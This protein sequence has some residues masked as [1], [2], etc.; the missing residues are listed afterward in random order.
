MA[1]AVNFAT[2]D[3]LKWGRQ[4]ELMCVLLLLLLLLLAATSQHTMFFNHIFAAIQF[5]ATISKHR[6]CVTIHK[7]LCNNTQ[8]DT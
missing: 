5:C 4:S 6:N 8:T 1:E 7:Q 2:I 3:W